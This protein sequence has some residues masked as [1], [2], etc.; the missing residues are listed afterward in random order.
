MGQVQSGFAWRGTLITL[1]VLGAIIA[2]GALLLPRGFSN[3][4]AQIGR[5]TPVMVLAHD[6]DTVYSQ[7]VMEWMNAIRGDYAGR[8]EFVVVELGSAPDRAFLDQQRIRFAT[9]LLFGPDGSRL[10]TLDNVADEDALRA[11]LDTALGGR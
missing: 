7:R 10:A 4:T 9:V 8:V 6:K 1:A 3:D 5:G 2:A 11:A